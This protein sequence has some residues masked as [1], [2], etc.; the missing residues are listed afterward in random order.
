MDI[1]YLLVYRIVLVLFYFV[2]IQDFIFFV[3]GDYI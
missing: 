1:S 3:I 2:Y